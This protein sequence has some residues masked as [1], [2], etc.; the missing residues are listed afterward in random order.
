MT[1][2]TS[3]T[4]VTAGQIADLLAWARSLAEQGLAAD[5]AERAAFLATKRELLD[6]L[7]THQQHDIHQHETGRRH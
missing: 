3:P 5:P 4:P 6:R 7:T 1:N 2:P